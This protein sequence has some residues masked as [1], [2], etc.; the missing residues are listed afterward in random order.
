V[1]TFVAG[2][3]PLGDLTGAFNRG[4][5]TLVIVF[6]VSLVTSTSLQAVGGVGGQ[7]ASAPAGQS[8]SLGA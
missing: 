8:D 2:M 6:G 1:V 3:V 5:E 4:V 7:A